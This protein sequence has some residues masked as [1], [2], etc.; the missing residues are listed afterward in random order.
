M[1]EERIQGTSR[2][3]EEKHLEET[4]AVIHD[5]MEK[6]GRQVRDMQAD[7]DEMLE[8]YHDNDVEVYT[9]LSNTITM[10]DH[11]K[12]ALMRNEK[13]SDKPYFGRIVF[14]D[15]ATGLTESKKEVSRGGKWTSLGS[16]FVEKFR[17]ATT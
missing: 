17:T 11:M 2:R 10:H 5:N 7:I 1:R 3:D 12:R 14:R 9:I 4:L 8:H 16:F 15:F 6:Y 13:A